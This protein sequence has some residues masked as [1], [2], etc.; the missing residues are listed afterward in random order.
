MACFPVAQISKIILAAFVGGSLPASS[1]A[2]GIYSYSCTDGTKESP[3]RID[4]NKKIVEWRG[5]KYNIV[6]ANGEDTYSESDCTAKYCW[7]AHGHG[8]ELWI[9]VATKGM[10]SFYFHEKDVACR[11][12]GR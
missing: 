9:K 2:A 12:Y 3:L 10:A 4:E 5:K 7:L 8:D 1:Y 6:K 11:Q